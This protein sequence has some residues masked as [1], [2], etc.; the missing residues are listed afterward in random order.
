MLEYLFFNQQI[1]DRF[2]DFLQFKTTE[3]GT[4]Y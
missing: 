4:E 3:M 1:A 2:T